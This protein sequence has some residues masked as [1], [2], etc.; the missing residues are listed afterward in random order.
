VITIVTLAAVFTSGAIA[1][2]ITLVCMSI[3]GEETR[4]SLYK[5]PAKRAT[6]A[7]R[8]LLGWHGTYRVPQSRSAIQASR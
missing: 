2:V 5:R 1:G 3:R 7:T 6:A 4:N 8:R